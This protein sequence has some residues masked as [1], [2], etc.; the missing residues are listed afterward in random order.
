MQ[1]VEIA[2]PSDGGMFFWLLRLY[3]FAGCAIAAAVGFV[4]FGV[5]LHFCK[6]L[7]AIPD[8]TTYASTAP[9]MTTVWAQDGTLLA[10]LSTER[11]EIVPLDHVP[12]SL[13]DAFLSTEDRRFFS[14]GGFDVRGTLRAFAANLRAGGVKQGGS[15]IT[16][17]VAK[18]FLSS[19]RSWSRKVKELIFAR[20]LEARY[21]KR[22]I[23]SLYINHIFLGNGAYGVQAAARKYFDKDVAELDV[24]QQAL[25]AGLA[26]APS[27]YSPFVD[28]DAALKRRGD[29][30]DNMVANAVLTRAEGDRWKAAP[31]HVQGRRDYF[32][33]ITPYFTEQVRRDLIKRLGQKQFYEGGWRVETTVLPWVDQLAQDNV[34]HAVRK[35]DKRQGWRGPEVR[36][37]DAEAVAT[38]KKRAFE[39]YGKGPLVEDKLYV[40]LVEKVNQTAAVVRVGGRSYPL[41]LENMLWAAPYSAADATNDKQITAASEALKRGDVVWV[42]WAWHSRI[43]RFSDFTYNEEGEASWVAEQLEPKRAPKTQELLLEQT[44]RVQG[45]IFAFDHRDGYVTAVAGGDDFDR[46]E[47]N[48]VT[49]ACRQPGSAYK[50]IYYSLALDRGYA[51][52]TLWNDKLKAEIDPTTGELWIPQNVDGSYNAQVTLERALVW[53]K[54]PPSVEIFHILGSKDVEKWA[55]RLGLTT[56]LVTNAKCEKEFCSSLAL[57]AS[58]VHVDEMTKAFAVFAKNGRPIDPIFVRRV[59]DRRGQVVEDHSSWDDPWLEGDARLDRVAAVMGVERPPVIEPRTAY[60]TSKLLREIVTTGHSAPIRAT[61]VLAAGKTGTSSRTSD[62]WFI[63]YTSRWMATAWLGDDKY[64]RQLGYKDASFMLSVPMWARFMYSAVGEQPLEEIPWE[65]PAKV[66]ASD[67]GGPLK[68]EFAP[69]PLPGFDVSGKPILPPE[70]LRE[71]L[72]KQQ[73]GL[74]PGGMTPVGMTPQR[75]FV[76]QKTVR[77]QSAVKPSGIG[78]APLPA[79]KLQSPKPQPQKPPKPQPP[80]SAPKR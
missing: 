49:Q 17:Q 14:H 74:A 6:E 27:R 53:S 79:T 23:L 30:L 36:L 65:R 72:Q 63:G 31:L 25:I 67:A 70:K 4:A 42:K 69:P 9:G 26:Q 32:H 2:N 20:R 18:A 75:P 64:E 13:I 34:D 12:Q 47:F 39:L 46:S 28:E 41:P 71:Q 43:P 59:I 19:E 10:E 61:K 33:E 38:F 44:P 40:G 60:L 7:P 52:D 58:C 24:G 16:Q 68:K 29:V 62:V 80:R 51:F 66:K 11:R 5:Y 35:L 78:V 56:P 48:R 8:L 55:R 3:A 54:N 73:T 45:A 37:A 50:P 1:R 76:P 57:G 22:E 21:T 77:V 15:T